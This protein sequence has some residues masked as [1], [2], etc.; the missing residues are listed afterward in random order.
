LRQLI[1]SRFKLRNFDAGGGK[2]AIGGDHLLLGL[3]GQL[4]ESLSKEFDM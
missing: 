2:V 3:T 1:D 4:V